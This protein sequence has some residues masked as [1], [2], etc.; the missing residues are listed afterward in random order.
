[1]TDEQFEAEYDF[2]E[3]L[4]E[5]SVQCL[6]EASLKSGNFPVGFDLVKGMATLKTAIDGEID[7]LEREPDDYLGLY[8]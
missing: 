3:Q 7:Y 8:D 5:L 2:L 6:L 1:M 4:K